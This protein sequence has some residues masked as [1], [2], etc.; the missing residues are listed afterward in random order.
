MVRYILVLSVLALGLARAA[1]GAVD[2]QVLYN[3][4]ATVPD[5]MAFGVW[6]AVPGDGTAISFAPVPV[7]PN[8]FGIPLALQ[9]RYQ[10]ARIDFPVPISTDNFLGKGDAFLEL[11]LRSDAFTP[12]VRVPMPPLTGLR[13]TFFTQDG[14]NTLVAPASD[15]Y[16][17]DEVDGNWVRLAIPLN[18]LNAKYPLGGDLHR[19]LIMADSPVK[20]LLGR[21]AFIR[22]VTML[23]ARIS[24]APA[25]LRA[26]EPVNLSANVDGGL[27]PCTVTWNLGLTAD[28]TSVDATGETVTASFPKAGSYTITCTVR[29]R[30]GIKDPITVT[31]AITIKDT[32][33]ARAKVAI[34][35]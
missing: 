17:M 5:N 31:G 27:T 19:L 1:L 8:V 7:A 20:L 12:S 11:Y 25:V 26:G 15:F 14:I 10:G 6:G 29:D 21:F 18:R 3:G 2:M 35:N 16:P 9:G 4:Q 13:V 30:D 34:D 28:A 32:G 23:R 24:T 33:L 22:D